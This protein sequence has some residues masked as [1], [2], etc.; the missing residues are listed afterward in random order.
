MSLARVVT[1]DGGVPKTSVTAG[2]TQTCGPRAPGP[3]PNSRRCSGALPGPGAHDRGRLDAAWKMT[4]RERPG[5]PSQRGRGEGLS[6]RAHLHD[7]ASLRGGRHSRWSS[8]AGRTAAAGLRGGQEP[9]PRAPVGGGEARALPGD[10]GRAG[11]PQD[12][13][14]RHD[15]DLHDPA[16]P[17]DYPR[18]THEDA[19]RPCSVR[20]PSEDRREHRKDSSLVMRSSSQNRQA[21]TA[22]G[23]CQ[24]PG[25]ARVR[26]RGGCSRPP[27]WRSPRATSR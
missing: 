24:E 2:R 15:R 18:Q 10:R 3:Q 16:V 4:R 7:L 23:R 20:G 13:R 14:H 19:P 12:R 11:A 9:R 26:G 25:G 27:P 22:D 8:A 6:G 21:C 1:P 5:A 17:R